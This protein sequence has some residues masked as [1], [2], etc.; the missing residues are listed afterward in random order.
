MSALSSIVRSLSS[1]P[2]YRSP[3]RP[4][5]APSRASDV[6]TVVLG[7]ALALAAC[8]VLLGVAGPRTSSGD[9]PDRTA[10]SLDD[11]ADLVLES[12]LAGADLAAAASQED[13]GR[14]RTALDLADAACVED[15]RATASLAIHGTRLVE[16]RGGRTTALEVLRR[17]AMTIPAELAPLRCAPIVG[18]LAVLMT[19]GP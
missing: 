5:G 9:R 6:W 15:R 11:P 2:G 19:Y 16:Q 1:G 14:Y 4:G 7:V 13:L 17:V 8:L 12:E 18:S 3:R 10:V